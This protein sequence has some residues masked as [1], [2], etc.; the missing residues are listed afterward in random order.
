[1]ICKYKTRDIPQHHAHCD[2][3]DHEKR[4]II[5]QANVTSDLSHVTLLTHM[6]FTAFSRT[7]NEHI[8]LVLQALPVQLHDSQQS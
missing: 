1:M 5:R 3:S 2:Q 7:F 4:Y 8:L 6:S